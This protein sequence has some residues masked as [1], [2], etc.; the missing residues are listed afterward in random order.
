[1]GG[2]IAVVAS[3]EVADGGQ[4]GDTGVGGEGDGLDNG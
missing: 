1:M 4:P 3:P 2:T